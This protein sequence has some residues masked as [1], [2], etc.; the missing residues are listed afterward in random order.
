[1]RYDHI[2]QDLCRKAADDVR[3]ILERTAALLDDPADRMMIAIFASGECIGSAGGFCAALIKR[4]T[5][6]GADPEEVVDALWEM[7]R[8]SALK[9]CGGSDEP[10]RKL[11]ARVEAAQSG[12][13]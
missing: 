5:G 4:D 8:P 12:A 2:T 6:Q 7:I 10:F 3:G 1:M 9:S 13:A 11:L